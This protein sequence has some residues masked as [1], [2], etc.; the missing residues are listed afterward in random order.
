MKKIFLLIFATVGLVIF[1]CCN[2][3][4]DLRPTPLSGKLDTITLDIMA[5]DTIKQMKELPT[6]E[7]CLNDNKNNIPAISLNPD[8]SKLVDIIKIVDTCENNASIKKYIRCP[9]GLIKV[10]DENISLDFYNMLTCPTKNNMIDSI[11]TLILMN[12]AHVTDASFTT[13]FG[14]KCALDFF[15]KPQLVLNI[16]EKDPELVMDYMLLIYWQ[17][18]DVIHYDRDEDIGYDLFLDFI[19]SK[20]EDNEIVDKS[21]DLIKNVVNYS[22]DIHMQ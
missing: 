22:V 14:Y 5:F 11:N 10:D 2:K 1:N 16:Y 7:K 13:S 17:T 18:R 9:Y 6:D 15:N 20:I 12:I 3:N 4:K 19:K 21:T 8:N